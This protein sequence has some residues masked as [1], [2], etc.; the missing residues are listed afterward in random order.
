MSNLTASFEESSNLCI[1]G[2][3]SFLVLIPKE[4]ECY[5]DEC[6]DHADSFEISLFDE[7]DACYTCDHDA[8]MN[9]ACENDFAT[10]IYDNTCYFDK[11]YDNPLFVPTSDMHDNEEVFLENLYDNALDDDP[12]LLDDI[13]YN[14]TENGIG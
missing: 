5:I 7:I 9:D 3:S 10:V 6:D 13:N 1:L 11:F 14:I 8:R 12:M 2:I 4:D